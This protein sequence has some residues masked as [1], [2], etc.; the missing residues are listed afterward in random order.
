MK[1]FKY[2]LSFA[3]LGIVSIGYAQLGNNIKEAVHNNKAIKTNKA[4]LKRDINELKQFKKKVRAF[5]NAFIDHKQYLIKELKIDLLNAMHREINQSELKINQDKRELAQS[6]SEARNSSLEAKKSRRDIHYHNS[7]KQR[8]EY[9]DDVRDRR[10]DIRDKQ[11]DKRDLLA[12][13]ARTNEQKEILNKIKAF[14]FLAKPKNGKRKLTVNAKLLNNFIKTM[15]ADIKATKQEIKE[16]KKER[17]EDR[18]ER[19]EDY[20]G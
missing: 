2:V 17:R 16:D 6:K 5:E 4:Q 7:T 11:D 18:K 3:F 12:Q 9:F 13:I 10:D 15:E 1:T 20:R 8:R 19:R 14:N